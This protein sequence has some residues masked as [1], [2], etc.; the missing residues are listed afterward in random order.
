MIGIPGSFETTKVE[1][2]SAAAKLAFENAAIRTKLEAAVKI[3]LRHCLAEARLV[4]IEGEN[5]DV[6]RDG[7]EKAIAT[8][9]AAGTQDDVIDAIE[10]VFRAAIGARIAG[11]SQPPRSP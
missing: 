10:S 3:A 1:S 2:F 6:L 7:V 5:I 9:G 8:A 4:Y 11:S